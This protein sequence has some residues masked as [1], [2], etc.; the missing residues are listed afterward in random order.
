MAR[1]DEEASCFRAKEVQKEMLDA[2]SGISVPL[3]VEP[4]CFVGLSGQ[5]EE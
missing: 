3:L 5:V 2:Q 4:Y 1:I